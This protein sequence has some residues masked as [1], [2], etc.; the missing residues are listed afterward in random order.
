MVAGETTVAGG[1]MLPPPCAM[2]V[3][4]QGDAGPRPRCS[5]QPSVLMCWCARAAFTCTCV[6]RV[7]PARTSYVPPWRANIIT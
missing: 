6:Q 2:C 1:R 5:P 4:G 7:V 3:S